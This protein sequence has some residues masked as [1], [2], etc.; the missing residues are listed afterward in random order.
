MRIERF[1]KGNYYEVLGVDRDSSKEEIKSAFRDLA[2]IYHPDRP[3]HG[4][5]VA[6]LEGIIAEIDQAEVFKRLV[7][8]Y[9]VL[10]DEK[11]RHRYDESLGDLPKQVSSRSIKVGSTSHSLRAPTRIK[12][13]M[14]MPMESLIARLIKSLLLLAGTFG[15]SLALLELIFP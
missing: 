9:K 11:S 2:Q 14:M 6:N 4:G 13:A 8:A 15:I 7:T 12:P 10:I 1:I 5:L 3:C